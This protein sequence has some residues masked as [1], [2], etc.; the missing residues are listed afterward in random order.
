M[1]RKY[2][3]K[4]SLQVFVV[5]LV[6]MLTGCR[7]AFEGIFSDDIAAGDEVMFT[8][9]LRRTVIT[10]SGDS[11]YSFVKSPYTFTISMFEGD[12]ASASAVATADYTVV[13]NSNDGTL[14]S[15][16]PLYWPSNQKAYRFTVTAGS[17]V[18]SGTQSLFADWLKQDRLEG[19]SPDNSRK[20]SE[21]KRYNEQTFNPA[22]EDYKKI[23][24]YLK[25]KRSQI[26]VILK[27][28][29]GVN[30]EALT[31]EAAQKDISATIFSY[32]S[33]GSSPLEIVPLL[34]KYEE[35]GETTICYKAI[36]AP[37]D[38]S[39]NKESDLIAKIRLS[40]Q[41]FSFYAGND[42]RY[43]SENLTSEAINTIDNNYKLDEGKHLKLTVKLS[44]DSRNVKMMA[45]IKDWDEEVNNLICDDFGNQGSPIKI[46]TKDA[47]V[48]FLHNPDENKAGNVAFLEGDA[49]FTIDDTWEPCSLNCTLN[50]GGKTI[51]IKKRFFSTI[52]NV[53]S[54][55]NGTI[56]A[57]D[58]VDAAI[59][60]TNN[61]TI[62]DVKITAAANVYA[63][64]AGAVVN[65]KGVIS[66][67]R[68]AIEVK[69]ANG[70]DYVGGIAATSLSEGNK[71]AIINACTVTNR[72]AGSNVAGGIVGQ[73]SGT[74]SNNTFEYGITLRQNANHK[75]IV[76][77]SE[78]ELLAQGNAW[79]TKA[80][81]TDGMENATPE[82]ERYDGI[83]DAVGDFSLTSNEA[84]K[85][86]RIA[87]DIIIQ[88]SE[89][90]SQSSLGEVK[91]QLE[92]NNKTFY[93]DKMIFSTISGSV[94][95]LVVKVTTNLV[96]T[97]NGSDQDVMAPLAYSVSGEQAKVNNVKVYTDDNKIQASNP[98]G[99]VVWAEDGAT[100]SNCEV[101][102]NVVAEIH[103]KTTNTE[104]KYAGGIVALAAKATVT[105]C[106]FHSASK[107]PAVPEATVLYY[108][109]IVGGIASKSGVTPE[110]TI[111]DCTNFCSSY[112]TNPEGL[113]HG[114]ILGY[115][116]KDG[117]QNATKGCQGNWWPDNMQGKASKGVAAIQDGTTADAVIGKR[118]SQKPTE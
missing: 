16:A 56:Q 82:E 75:N 43:E 34:E 4:L 45:A 24:L 89:T 35:G 115:A 32:G 17:N 113:Y 53:A 117:G 27:A 85:S 21:W 66:K 97:N 104:R 6:I 37:Y 94:S 99:L 57:E 41:N 96:A 81:A 9:S 2:I 109:G 91:Y 83:I 5:S 18:L 38:Y 64:K 68:S 11:D 111:T 98:A 36:V 71:T 19:A 54:L 101:T 30:P 69:G 26:T 77:V 49:D 70:V 60:E 74:V 8:T 100:I 108:G 110:L 103:N 40:N 80:K 65:N 44:R 92:G 86:Y 67:C 93:T 112:I 1:N 114:G 78:G 51:K 48:A 10:R 105:Q 58:N 79:P 61:G 116:M 90:A 59:A 31:Y 22:G 84:T 14:E 47:L 12:D 7:E 29:E 107:L 55:Q 95:N 62:E 33:Y 72:V 88:N 118:N 13:N 102:A 46:A 3:L 63:T 15:T 106:V 50:L 25:H 73:A 76:G 42:S 39:A 20:P 87:R 23:P 28:G 52:G